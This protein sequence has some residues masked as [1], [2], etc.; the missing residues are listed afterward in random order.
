M[1]SFIVVPVSC[2]FFF[3]FVV[4]GGVFFFVVC[5][6]VSLLAC[7]F[8]W[9]VIF[10]LFVCYLFCF[11]FAFLIWIICLFCSVPLPEKSLVLTDI[12]IA[13]LACLLV[14]LVGWFLFVC[15]VLFCF[16]FVFVF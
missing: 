12:Q 3:Y 6:S 9:L 10:C 7:L 2:S 14:W 1:L 15:F 5:L 8:C 11:V 13:L 4:V 16:N